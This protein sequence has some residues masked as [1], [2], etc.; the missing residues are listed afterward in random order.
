MQLWVNT[1]QR[2]VKGKSQILFDFWIH[3]TDSFVFCG[4]MEPI[5][6]GIMTSIWLFQILELEPKLQVTLSMVNILWKRRAY[7]QLNLGQE[8][9]ICKKHPP[10]KLNCK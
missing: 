5:H 10:L 6:L 2:F 1:S 7:G 3:V 9:I 8:D 4:T